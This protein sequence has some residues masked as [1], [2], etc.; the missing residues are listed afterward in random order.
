MQIALRAL[1][2]KRAHVDAGFIGRAP[3]EFGRNRREFCGVEVKEERHMSI[4]ILPNFYQAD[5]NFQE[6]LCIFFF[7]I[8]AY[9]S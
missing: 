3:T 8:F 2:F 5:I 9:F 4:L 7:E 1:N 6:T